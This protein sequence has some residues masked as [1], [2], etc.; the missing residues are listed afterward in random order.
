MPSEWVLIQF[1]SITY[2]KWK[3]LP[4]GTQIVLAAVIMYTS[5]YSIKYVW[6]LPVG[7]LR[8]YI[9]YIRVTAGYGSPIRKCHVVRT[10]F[11]PWNTLDNED[12][13]LLQR[14]MGRDMGLTKQG[15]LE[16]VLWE[17]IKRIGNPRKLPGVFLVGFK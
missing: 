13:F 15:A 4:F 8:Y 9:E 6:R 14:C 1:L 2:Y 12:W 3:K 10:T 17:C 7:I 16:E 5:P 11:N